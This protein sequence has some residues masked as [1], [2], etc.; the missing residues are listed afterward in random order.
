MLSGELITCVSLRQGSRGFL[1]SSAGCKSNRNQRWKWLMFISLRICAY[2]LL[3][4][5]YEMKPKHVMLTQMWNFLS[6]KRKQWSWEQADKMF[7]GKQ[8]SLPTLKAGK[9][10]HISEKC[11]EIKLWMPWVRGSRS[12]IYWLWKLGRLIFLTFKF[13][14]ILIIFIL[15]QWE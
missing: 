13:L 11:I 3:S 9:Q 5:I 15:F 10:N 7:L 6:H 2:Y 8:V 12:A 1:G 4:G 14:Q